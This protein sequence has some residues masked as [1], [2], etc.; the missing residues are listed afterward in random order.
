MA[1]ESE[2]PMREDVNASMYVLGAGC[3]V[4]KDLPPPHKQ[5]LFATEV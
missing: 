5:T 2:Q 1:G 3:N 4:P